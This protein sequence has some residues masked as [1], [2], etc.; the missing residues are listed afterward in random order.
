MFDFLFG[1]EKNVYKKYNNFF[2]Y[3]KITKSPNL[4]FI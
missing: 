4:I 2:S 1:D 3:E